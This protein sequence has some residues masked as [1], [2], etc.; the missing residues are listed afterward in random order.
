MLCA[1]ALFMAC[2]VSAVQLTPQEA[3]ARMNSTKTH[4]KGVVSENSSL[5]LVYTSTFKGITP[6]M[7]STKA[8][9][10]VSSSLVPTTVCQ[11]F[12]VW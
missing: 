7:Y 5:Q 9:R 12:L 6:T 3:L 8:M 1:M 10:R 4:A 11:P 2:R